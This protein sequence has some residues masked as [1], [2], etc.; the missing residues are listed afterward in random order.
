MARIKVKRPGGSPGVGRVSRN[1]PRIN[2]PMCPIRSMRTLMKRDP[3]KGIQQPEFKNTLMRAGVGV[4]QRIKVVS[5]QR[6]VTP[7]SFSTRPGKSI[8][9]PSPTNRGGVRSPFHK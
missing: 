3:S 5:R 4:R 6:P 8:A 9:P 1:W 2:K 7:P